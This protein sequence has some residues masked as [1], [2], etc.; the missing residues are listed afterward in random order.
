MNCETA[1][2]A[3]V[4]APCSCSCSPA[5]HTLGQLDARWTDGVVPTLVGDV[6]RVRTGLD[7]AD[8]IGALKV[9]CD[10]GRT[11]Y[12]VPPGLYAIGAPDAE[13]L[14]FVSA[15]YK[16]SFD[17]LRS[18]LSGRSAWILVLDTKGINVWCAAGKGT[19]GTEEIVGRVKSCALDQIVSHRKLVLPQLGAPGV[20]AHEVRRRCGFRVEYG[21]VRADDLPAFLDAG[22]KATPEMR[23]VR[24]GLWDRMVLVPVDLAIEAKKALLVAAAMV[25]LGGLSSSGY[26]MT[27]VRTIGLVSAA[28]VI[29]SFLFAGVV[30]P[31]LLPWLPGHA[32]SLK[33][34]VLGVAAFS[35]LAALRAG[36]AGSWLHLASWALIMPTIASF[37]L[38]NFT[39][40]STFTSQSGVLREMRVAVPLQIAGGVIGLGLWLTGLFVAGGR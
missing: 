31:A 3:N 22:L 9:R 16:M 25:V 34:A 33:G 32:F 17:R 37:M 6:P 1:S 24:F 39:G 2:G 38:M 14:V 7:A 15:N 21:P 35:G 13:S 19:F 40:S 12:R 26:S 29:G 36:V 4:S 30:G 8:R 18:A 11:R 5:K 28:L 23:R 10:I 27:G 20:S